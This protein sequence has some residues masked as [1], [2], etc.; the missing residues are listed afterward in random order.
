MYRFIFIL[1]LF[2]GCAES[3][4]TI[5]DDALIPQRVK[6]EIQRRVK[7]GI[8][9]AIVIGV[10]DSS[11]SEI[12]YHGTEAIN[13]EGRDSVNEYTLFELGSI[14]KTFT[15]ILFANFI[16]DSN[17]SVD[18][19]LQE[20]LP[21]GVKAPSFNGDTIR[22]FHL[23]NHT[24]GLPNFPTDFSPQNSAN[25]FADYTNEQLLAFINSYNL[26]RAVGAEYEYS[27]TAFALVGH[28]VALKQQSN[29]ESLLLNKISIPLSLNDTRIGFNQSMIANLARGHKDGKIVPNWEFPSFAGAGGIKSNLRDMMKYLAANMGQKETPLYPALALSHRKTRAENSDP[30]VG[31][32]WHISK[33]GDAEIIWHNGGTG[34]YRTYIGFDKKQRKGVV[35][36]SNS[37]ESIDDIGIHILDPNTPLTQ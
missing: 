21:Q 14:S 2:V 28:L 35:V 34:G 23:L 22:L 10:I 20:L 29:Y 16:L 32:G 8:N 18:I 5:Q 12:Y 15:A 26:P 7:K 27:N 6:K 30:L 36:L 19:P 11:N 33:Q 9:P 1:L 17:Y 3:I 13:S 4:I 31:L 25:P 24:S 37:T